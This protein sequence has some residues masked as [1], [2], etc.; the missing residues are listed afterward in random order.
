MT[1]YSVLSFVVVFKSRHRV[2]LRRRLINMTI[3]N[4][5]NIHMFI[6]HSVTFTRIIHALEK[7]RTRT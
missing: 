5:T 7:V 3:Y 6:V 1:Y 4:I 2:S